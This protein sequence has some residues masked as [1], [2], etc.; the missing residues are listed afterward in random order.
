MK[1]SVVVGTRPGIIMMA[2]IIKAIED[3]NIC[4]FYVI[5]T[6]QHYSPEMDAWLFE[7]LKLKPPKYKLSDIDKADGH[8][9]K[10]AAMLIGCEEIFIKD[11]PD[12]VLVNG[13]A[14]TNLAAALAARKLG[15][16]LAHSEAG[17]RSYDWRM[18]EEHNRRIIDHISDLLFSTSNDSR[19]TLVS[20]S[21]LGSV[22]VTGNTI[23]DASKQHSHLARKRENSVLKKSCLENGEHYFLLTSH[24]EENVDNREI[25]KAI[26]EGVNAGA[27]D[28]GAKVLFPVHP[29]TLKNLKSFGL[30]D[31]VARLP[32]I[33]LLPAARYLDFLALLISAKVVITDSGGVQQEAYIHNVPTVTTRIVTE[34]KQTLEKGAN[35]LADPMSAQDI[36][37]KISSAYAD[38]SIIW[39]EPFGDGKAASR[40][41][42]HC[43]AYV[44]HDT[45]K[46]ENEC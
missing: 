11:R 31:F 20:E 32:Q 10:T 18:P 24:R 42:Q 16:S 34:W 26:I 5:H 17:E 38:D 39:G 22:H 13:D 45:I 25:L 28:C 43:L 37:S 27:S 44:K 4:D 14:N 23:V 2:P 8:A 9:R 35:R 36:S 46:K 6:G 1:I 12:L 33:T 19:D 41:V 21:V 7:D 15:I 29:R 3:E 30:Y 40:I